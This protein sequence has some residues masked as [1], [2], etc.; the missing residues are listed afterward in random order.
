MRIPG[1]ILSILLI[2]LPLWSV[3]PQNLSTYVSPSE[4]EWLEALALGEICYVQYLCLAEIARHGIDSSSRYLLDEIPDISYFLDTARAPSTPLEKDQQSSVSSGDGKPSG[5][6]A[7]V[8]RFDFRYLQ[9][10]EDEN[11]TWY[12]STSRL[13]VS[14]N[15]AAT[16]RINRESNGRERIVY[17]SFKYSGGNGLLR[18]A[19][20]GNFTARFGL[21]TLFG[22]RG[23]LMACSDRIN[24]ESL[25][26]PDYGGYNGVHLVGGVRDVQVQVLGSMV[27]DACHRL[28]SFGLMLKDRAG[29]LR[30]GIIIG[31]NDLRNRQIR[32]GTGLSMLALHSEYR[33]TGGHAIAEVAAQTGKGSGAVAAVVEG[34]HRIETAEIRFAGWL[35]GNRFLDLTS[36][37]KTGSIYGSLYLEEAE[38]EYSSKRTGQEGVLLKT[39][40]PLEK[41]IKITNALLLA[42]RD[43]YNTSTQYSCAL[44]RPLGGRSSVQLDF[45]WRRRVK[46]SETAA[47]TRDRSRWRL[48]G[49]FYSGGLYLRSY[50]GYNTESE[51]RGYLSLFASLRIGLRPRG[52]VEFWSN[53]NRLGGEGVEYWYN[54]V[55]GE[56]MLAGNVK[57][58]AKIAHTYRNDPGNRGS[59]TLSLGIV[60][61]L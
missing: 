22:Y 9:S 10:L 35:Y 27:R 37:S 43:R 6:R 14:E 57:A 30:P 16:W 24:A 15:L 12:R 11:K 39:V 7:I 42:H 41:S 56:Q 18:S 31:F 13:V 23:K 8:G 19:V 3:A 59:T 38:F 47:D 26:Y 20:L 50:I 46:H 51:R 44:S 52:L 34:R 60:A 28:A 36:G 21:G 29:K 45:L 61:D 1:G 2:V 32:Q 54:F 17:R 40:V 4:D 48:L 49:R 33:Y 55:R 58:R 5:A 53:L 25:A